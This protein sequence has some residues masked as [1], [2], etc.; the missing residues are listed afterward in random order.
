MLTSGQATA[1]GFVPRGRHLLAYDLLAIVASIVAAFALRF[2]ARDPVGMVAAFAPISLLPLVI[3]PL[4][5]VAFGLYRREWRYASVRELVAITAAVGTSTVVGSIAF[6]WLSSLG[7]AGTAG[8]PRSFFPLEG[9]VSLL[10]LGGGR[11]ALRLI[12]EN[13]GR[14]GDTDD[15][16]GLIRTL[17]Y[18]AGEAGTTLARLARRD[19]SIGMKVVGFLDDDPNK[20]G[21]RLYGARISGDLSTL[22]RTIRER[23]ASQL[24]VAMPSASGT[25]IRA[26]VE[27]AQDLGLRVRIVPPLDELLGHTDRLTR[28]RPVSLE[29]LLRRETASVDH[30]DLTQYLNAASVLVTGGGG[31][32]GSELVRQILVLGPRR[33][34]VVDNSEVALW[35]IEREVSARL[36]GEPTV[37]ETI[38]ADVRISAALD[39]AIDRSEADVVFH[40]AALK[41]VPICE[42]H[43]SE[44]VLTNV[45]GT[46]NVVAACD[47]GRVGQFVL[48]STD[49]AVQPVSVM[50]AT[51]R[52]AELVT[53]EAAHRVSRPY[54]AVRFGNVLGSSGSVVPIFR[55]QLERGGP[56]TVTDPEATRYFMTIPEAVTL[57]LKAG[58]DATPGEIYLLDMGDPVRILDLA[59]DMI[60]L[61]G[62]A[63]DSVEI[64]F[65]GLRPGERLHEQLLFDHESVGPTGHDR[66]LRTLTGGPSP[67]T[68]SVSDLVDELE[69]LAMRSDDRAVRE[70]L[71]ASGV[72]Q[73]GD[74]VAVSVG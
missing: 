66:V 70:R 67:R 71:V 8:L 34:T 11:F 14:S 12:L 73:T 43:P 41:H 19:R 13:A 39:R 6:V 22:A 1:R 40:A 20:R 2:D 59:R 5:N 61:S 10:L 3:Q 53:V 17:I 26:A 49:K 31:S 35:T 24:V 45:V 46:R 16:Q 69:E 55:D 23:R 38:L 72:L 21:S 47:R 58:S 18:G 68:G 50:G 28:V 30:D 64:Q 25:R 42:L 32:I 60:R 48:I 15:E 29:D 27:Q 44:A 52:I 36:R 56:L 54:A 62:L 65:T 9:I 63:P 7:A 51:K 4:V 33:L 57:I 37:L 74:A